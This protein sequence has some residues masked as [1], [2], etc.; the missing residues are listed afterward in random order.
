VSP[1]HET[2]EL[3][4]EM[5]WDPTS[6]TVAR[7]RSPRLAP[8]ISVRL[9]FTCWLIFLLHFAT[10]TVREIYPALSLGDRLSFDVSEYAGFH[11]DIFEIPGRGA[12]IN[13][14]PGAS[15]LGAVPYALARPLI[16][17]GVG[18][19]QRARVAS[20]APATEYRTIYPM[21]REFV[22]KARERGLDVKFGL[23]AG[24]MQAFV[25]A[26]LSAASV[27]V[28]FRVLSNLTASTWGALWLALLYGFATPVL[29][30][31]AQLNQNLLVAHFAF[32]AFVLL[33]RPGH[34]LGD[35]RRPAYLLAGLLAG[36]T[37]VLDYSGLVVLAVLAAY[38]LVRRRRLPEEARSP[39]DVW[40]FAGGVVAS[41][42]VLLA[43]QWAA[44]GHPLWPAQVYMPPATF[45]GYGY[46]GMDWPRLDLLWNTAFD[47]RYGLFVSAPILLLALYAP[48]WRRRGG[49]LLGR[50][51]TAC[52]LLLSAL[53]FVFCAANQYGRL[54]FNSGVRHIVP[55]TPFLFLLVAG[56]LRQMPTIVAVLLGIVTTYWSWCLAM[57][58]DVEQ[59][60][61]VL[62][63]IIHVS[64]EGFR[65]PWITTLERLGLLES[66]ASVAPL[67]TVTAALLWALW[68]VPF[69][70][71]GSAVLGRPRR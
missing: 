59:G 39:Q 71:D 48:A 30:R 37:V 12:F 24:V 35:S 65:L 6:L 47:L 4:G 62:E 26:P 29:Y 49:C 54:Q 25:M 70:A 16:D 13:N 21:A 58:R 60:L 17:R 57:Y 44:F 27:V 61:G 34:A 42:A 31:T 67:F 40:R 43:Y 15:I 55:V 45:T 63:S 3:A 38:A 50:P 68:R 14:N 51:E 56:V 9:F 2:T 1:L 20:P 28:M 11:P 7:D 33:W 64:L 53:L 36:W 23:G 52:M 32:F 46:R 41:L 69:G 22:R 66:S 5:T 8:S 18:W 19:V 10:N